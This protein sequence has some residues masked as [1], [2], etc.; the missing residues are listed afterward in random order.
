MIFE[1]LITLVILLFTLYFYATFIPSLR[2]YFMVNKIHGPKGL[3]IL[4]SALDINKLKYNEIL[5]YFRSQT[6][7]YPRVTLIWLLGV[8]MVF[9]DEPEDVAEVLGNVSNL[10]KGV[11]YI[12]IQPWLKEGLLLS[13]GEKWHSRRKLLT[14][15]F[16]FRLLEENLQSMERHAQH[17][18]N[19]LCSLGD[20][21]IDIRDYIIL[22]TLDVMCDTAMGIELGALDNPS[23]KYVKCVK[24][25][26]E[27]T[28]YRMQNLY[29][30]RDWLFSLTSLGKQFKK[31]LAELHD[32][33][34]KII[35]ERKSERRNKVNKE[36]NNQND[37]FKPRKR[38]AF[39]D[40][41]LEMDIEHKLTE[42]DI[43]EEVDTFL[44]EGHDTTAAAITFAIYLLGLHQDVQDKLIEEIDSIIPDKNEPI[45]RQ[46]LNDMKYMD[47][48]VKES[49]RVY[50][51][52]PYIS[53]LFTHDIKLKGGIV[54]PAGANVGVLPYIMHRKPEIYPEPEK[55]DPERFSPENISSRHPYAYIPFSAG[56]RNCIGQKFALMEIKVVLATLF[57]S[58]RVQSLTKRED[59]TVSPLL[60]LRSDVP[61]NIK[62][63]P[64]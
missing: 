60:V 33:T 58:V 57:K 9:L 35:R 47:Q 10:D 45:T 16:H 23:L 28:I 53:R 39:L 27:V 43:R 15:T 42:A 50:P 26:G 55:F 13:T 36:E 17:L 22:C 56:P 21:T 14:P 25:V 48:V 19:K 11:E 54:I 5:E 52:V 3:P 4:G 37:D 31:D 24:S 59:V 62:V 51:S 63:T 49:L 8:P 2:T 7:K 64:R 20:K 34:T 6:R 61:L 32:F 12:A 46:H 44:F 38:K 1:I 29:L 30:H 18:V 40:L 41:L